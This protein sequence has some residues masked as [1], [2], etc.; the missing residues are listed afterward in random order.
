MPLSV[1]FAC[2]AAYLVLVATLAIFMR[3]GWRLRRVTVAP[4]TTTQEPVPDSS[5]PTWLTELASL[6]FVCHESED[7]SVAAKAPNEGYAICVSKPHPF[8]TCTACGARAMRVLG[9]TP[10]SATVDRDRIHWL[11]QVCGRCGSAII[12]N[13]NAPRFL[14]LMLIDSR[15]MLTFLT[16]VRQHAGKPFNEMVAAL[17]LQNEGTLQARANRSSS[18]RASLPPAERLAKVL[19]FGKRPKAK[20]P[21][22]DLF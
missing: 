16:Q 5:P 20:R 10:M 19:L 3:R 9:E 13:L 12:H 2:A 11:G 6:G 17:L 15:S 21:R 22:R 4:E 18:L 14:V 7:A 8:Q 1:L